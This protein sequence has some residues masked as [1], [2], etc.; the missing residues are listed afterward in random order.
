M[1]KKDYY[2]ILGIT[3]EEKKLQGEE[4]S[5]IVK[6]KYKKLAIKYH[7][8]KWSNASEAERKEAEDKFK[9]INEANSILSDQQKRQQYDMGGTFD[10]GGFDPFSMFADFFGGGG[11]QQHQ[12]RVERGTDI[13][14]KVEVTLEEILNGCKK[15][16]SGKRLIPCSKCNGTGSEDGM[17]ATCQYC[18][19]SG[20]RTVVQRMGN[21]IFQS[22]S[23]C[24][25]CGGTGKIVKNKCKTCNGTGFTSETFK[26]NVSIP[27]GA[28]TGLKLRL[29]GAGNHTKSK[30]GING[31]VYVIV[32]EKKHPIFTRD[33][34]NLYYTLELD[35]DEAWCGCEK[36]IPTIEGNKAKIKISELTENGKLLRI[37][38]KGISHIQTNGRGDLYVEIS[39]KTPK[40]ITDEQKKILK[41]FYGRK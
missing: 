31:D 35:L 12:Q 32:I 13:E 40:A 5:N 28:V 21:S 10:M 16:I 33:G 17:E 9:E 8:D 30:N 14:I 27:K 19:G 20:Y 23:P 4:F 36:E 26:L 29:S 3:D 6:K 11:R 24:Q 39:Y 34:N 38:G 25:N 7:P 15:E 37:A 22:S 18:G 2:Q 1:E 41:E